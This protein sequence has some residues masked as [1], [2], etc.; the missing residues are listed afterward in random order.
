M[1]AVRHKNSTDFFCCYTYLFICDNCVFM[2][3]CCYAS[4]EVHQFCKIIQGS[5]NLHIPHLVPLTNA[6]ISCLFK[7]NGVVILGFIH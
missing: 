1:R 5:E 4:I 2:D 7:H 6:N 3:E